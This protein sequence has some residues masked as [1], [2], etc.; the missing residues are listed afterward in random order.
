M[1]EK[2]KRSPDGAQAQAL[3]LE[4]KIYATEVESGRTSA[5]RYQ[6]RVKFGDD[7]TTEISRRAFGHTLASAA[8]GDVI[9]VRYD[10]ADRSK[11]ELD[12][13]AMVEQENANARE[14]DAR[15]IARGERALGLS[16]IATPSTPAGDQ[17]QPDTGNLRIGDADRE[18]IAEVL[19]QHM[20]D[21]RLTTDELDDRLGALYT[22]QTREQARSVLAGLPPLAHSGGR[23]HEAIP[24]LPDWV[25]APEPAA[26][27]SPASMPA[28]RASAGVAGA[29]P[30]DGEMNTAYR[31]WQAKADRMK[32]DKATHK[33]AEASG[34]P[35]ATL[36]ALR[37]LTISSAEEKSARAKF[38]QLRKRRPD[39]TAGER[40]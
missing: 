22:A 33:Q 17:R 20:T 29:V 30:T 11:I 8:V 34:D 24:V 14:V 12:R 1:F 40:G 26:S 35:K 19:G 32:A 2:H 7:S 21:G 25:S 31:R 9:P 39:W 36:P 4:K 23:Q 37:K 5:C 28:G 3:V 13:H 18:L 15:A 10:P 38:E 6:L 27:R 16:S